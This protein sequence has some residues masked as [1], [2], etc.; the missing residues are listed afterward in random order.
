MSVNQNT[1]YSKIHKN[2]RGS[3]NRPQSATIMDS[4]FSTGFRSDMENDSLSLTYKT[5]LH[6][7][8]NQIEKE[9]D[10]LYQENQTLQDKIEILNEKLEKDAFDKPDCPDFETNLPKVLSKK[11][12][13]SS[14]K[15]KT[16]HKLKAQTSKIV[17]SFKAPQYS[18]GLVK[19]YVGH[20]DGVWEVSVARPGIP[21]I[22]TASADHTACIWSIESTK[23]LLQYQGHTGSVN[24]IRFHPSKD[25]VLTAGGDGIAHIWQAALNWDLPKGHSSEEELDECTEQ[26]VPNDDSPD[27]GGPQR[28]ASLRTPIGELM[29]HSGAVAAAE[30]LAGAELAITASW[31]RLAI[32]HDVETCTQLLTLTEVNKLKGTE[33]ENFL[34][35]VF[36]SQ[37]QEKSEMYQN[38]CTVL[39]SDLCKMKKEITDLKDKNS[40]AIFPG[41]QT[42]SH[43]SFADKVKCKPESI[44]I[45]KPKQKQESAET[46]R[47][48]RQRIN[49]SGISVSKFRQGK[50][51]A[52]IIGCEDRKEIVSLRSKLEETLGAEYLIA[53]PAMRKPK[54][55]VANLN[56]S[57]IDRDESDEDIVKQIV[58]WNNL[59][60]HNSF[61]MRV[62]KRSQNRH[63]NV[64]LIIEV[65]P[66]THK[67]LLD[68]VKINFGWSRAYVFNHVHILQCYNC[69]GFNHWAKDCSA[70]KVCS[71]CSGNHSFKDCESADLKCVN[72][73]KGHDQ[74]LTHTASHPTQ[75]LAVTSSRDTTFR[76][77]DFRETVHAVSVFQGHAE[78]VTSAV[79]T[80]EDKVVSSSDDRSV[81]V[82]DL[83]NMRS[84]V[85][86]IRVDSA[87]N[88][89]SVSA[90]GLIAI[91]HD[92]RHIRLFDLS[93]VR[94]ARLP[95]SS[96]QGHNRMV[97]CTAWSDEYLGGVNLFTCGFDRRVLGWSVASLK[98]I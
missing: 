61:H 7:L 91:P 9:F 33:M 97:A 83:R 38:E 29:G 87:V 72:C 71:R 73:I 84:P 54:L 52:V 53:E 74:E 94:V 58:K 5:R 23:C 79:F 35:K 43:V 4:D 76:L 80:R 25:L 48:I 75:K 22:G 24:S 78:S 95:R 6:V 39:K 64:D 17:S 67:V 82:W 59:T 18:S 2:K 8:F 50:D 55:K 93:G 11:L 32:L 47:E 20:K 10:L 66:I 90:N 40:T 13:S 37:L 31:D 12:S 49:P 46:K 36:V 19:E 30:W 56:G 98:D 27:V 51:G 42:I 14:Q 89:V 85:A 81:K 16:A 44:I 62:V 3:F 15:S 69:M 77:W 68:R 65:D 88:R 57:D 26:L 21:V 1:P 86:T 34:L 60:C 96:R 92:N 41:S 70:A 63:K 45:V 28:G